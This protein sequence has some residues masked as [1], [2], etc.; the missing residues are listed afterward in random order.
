[1]RIAR[2]PGAHSTPHGRLLAAPRTPRAGLGPTAG[3]R[4]LSGTLPPLLERLSQLTI[5]NI[6]SS[7]LGGTLPGELFNIGTMA[8]LT[9]S[10]NR[11]T[12]TLPSEIG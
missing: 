10:S 5:V 2:G 4:R 7:G 12:G 3:P 9:A 11:L 6:R 1:M 8:Q